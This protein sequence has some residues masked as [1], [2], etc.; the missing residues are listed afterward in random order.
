MGVDKNR[1]AYILKKYGQG[2]LSSFL[3]NMRLEYAVGLLKDEPELSIND[4]ASKSALPSSSTFFRL[5]KEKYGVSP[6][7]FREILGE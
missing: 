7:K 1:F 3:N 2:N 6:K 5:F 4:V